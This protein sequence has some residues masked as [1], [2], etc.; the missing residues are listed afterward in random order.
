MNLPA[1]TRI[2]LHSALQGSVEALHHLQL[3][4]GV[5]EQQRVQGLHAELPH[6]ARLLVAYWEIR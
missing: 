4:L 2:I 5:A 1:G 6:H 3:E